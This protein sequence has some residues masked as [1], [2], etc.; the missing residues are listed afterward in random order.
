[1]KSIYNII[2]A[3]I[4]LL[5]FYDAF[6]YA[7]APKRDFYQIKIYHIKDQAQQ[8]RIEQF[9][10]TA[11]LPALHRAG[12]SKVGVF[13]PIPDASKP[14]TAEQLVYVLI[15]FKSEK[16]FLTL[17][18]QLEKDKL[19]TA[20]G[21]DYLE[22]AYDN[23]PYARIESILLSAFPDHPHFELPALKSPKSERVYE[24]R[25]YEG[26]TEAKFK[27]K[28]QM[29]NEGG[30]IVLFKRLNFNAVFYASVVSGSKMPNLMYMTTFENKADRDAHWKTFVD[31]PEWKKLSAMPEYQHNV[32]H[33]DITFLRPTDYSD[34]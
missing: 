24:L 1:M 11:Y 15:P 23:P 19:F 17:E 10:Q 22:A 7:S 5:L 28:V 34:I 9:L 27:N 33:I 4:F 16:A 30:E 13:K 32:S 18:A 20:A 14:D 21:K 25:S 8:I 6:S 3:T 29:F 2:A 31:D 12:I 26:P